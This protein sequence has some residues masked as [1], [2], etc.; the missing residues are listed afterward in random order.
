MD[1]VN[2]LLRKTFF[3]TNTFDH[4][5]RFTKNNIFRFMST[6]AAVWRA[7]R[8]FHFPNQGIIGQAFFEDLLCS[9]SA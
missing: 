8:F 9:M 7:I 5:K 4:E 3:F 2:V 1:R 6:N